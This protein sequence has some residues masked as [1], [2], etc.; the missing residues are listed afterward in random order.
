MLG[1]LFFSVLFL[2]RA[3]KGVRAFRGFHG[4]RFFY[5]AAMGGVHG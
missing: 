1:S 5:G 3:F 2:C 4:G